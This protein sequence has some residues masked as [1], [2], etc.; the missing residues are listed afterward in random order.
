MLTRF[1]NPAISLTSLLFQRSIAL[2]VLALTAYCVVDYPF[3]RVWLSVLLIVYGVS[4]LF[5]PHLWLLVLP[6]V[7]P[8]LNLAP[9]SGRFYLEEFDFF[10]WVSLASAFWHGSYSLG[11]R[12]RF[13]ATPWLLIAFL[14]TTHGIATIRGL[15]PMAAVDV[16]A[17]SSYFSH[18]NALRISKSLVW[19]VLFIP[20]VQWAFTADLDRARRLLGYGIVIGLIGTGISVLW[21]RGVLGDLIYGENIY[22]KIQS[23]TD[24][25]SDY[26]I[27]ALFSE[28]HT[29]GEAVDGYIALT[30]PFALGLLI[31]AR[32]RWE[33][34]LGG[35]ALSAGLYSALVTFSRGT[36]LAVGVSLF[37]FA[38]ISAIRKMRQAASGESLKLA[39]PLPVIL[40]GMAGVCLLLYEKGGHYALIAAL[41]IFSGSVL[42]N[43]FKYFRRNIRTILMVFLLLAGFALMLRGLVTSKWVSNGIAESLAISLP[44]SL[45]LLVSGIFVGTRTRGMF[46]LRELGISMIFVTILIAVCV[47]ALSGSF[48]KSRFTTTQ[49]DFGGR[50]GHW[51]HAIELMD[52]GWDTSA[53]GMGLGTFPRSYLWGKE[54]EKTSMAALHQDE[55]NTYLRLSNS[56]DYAMGQRLGLEADQPYRLSLDTKVNANIGSL[57]MSVCR[58]NIIQ[59]WDTECITAS[60]PVNDKKWQ[61]LVWEFNIGQL[62]DG[63]SFGRRPLILRFTNFL[64]NPQSDTNL[65]LDF[66][67]I[68][69]IKLTDRYGENIV[70]N[71]HFENGLDNWFPSSDHYHLPLHIKNLWVN[72]YFEQGLLGIFALLALSLYTLTSAI[73]LARRGD[74][75][76]LSLLASLIGFFT[77]GLIG[78]LYDVPRVIFLFFLLMF[79]MLTQD[80]AHLKLPNRT[81]TNPRPNANQTPLPRRSFVQPTLNT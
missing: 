34:G 17:F 13:A 74:L 18:Y 32:S 62:G 51:Q 7:L 72:V 31:S 56:M 35:I 43:F 8:L 27:T 80:P 39:W 29:G 73:Q 70:I 6:I 9:W 4:L 14:V 59:P 38:L 44:V 46:N 65:P 81:R 25:S 1:S 49:D 48:M 11:M 54:T 68:D 2:A 75:F 76:A 61:H 58:R 67:D 24:F 69:N 66:I 26:R 28:M 78:T 16:N 71:G 57:T 53:F 22:A 40:V 42:L 79:I 36:Y 63:V 64:Y 19:A 55:I 60:K 10:I 3:A 15:L 21:E 77:V 23:L 50:L 37:T 47:P 41:G 20:P 30:W 52:L 5:L 33:I 12:P 45:G